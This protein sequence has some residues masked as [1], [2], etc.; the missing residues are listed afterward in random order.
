M[1]GNHSDEAHLPC[2]CCVCVF[3]PQQDPGVLGWV[4][5][6]EREGLESRPSPGEPSGA[7]A[8]PLPLS[9]SLKAHQVP[10][11]GLCAQIPLLQPVWLPEPSASPAG[12]ARPA[13][14]LGP[15]LPSFRGRQASFRCQAS[16]LG[17]FRPHTLA[18]AIPSSQNVLTRNTRARERAH[19]ACFEVLARPPSSQA[20]FVR[21]PRASAQEDDVPHTLPAL[22]NQRLKCWPVS[23]VL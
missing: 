6:L 18:H 17:L 5:G 13:A 1:K 19:L 15:Q 4:D 2:V 14:C 11:P 16:A 21:S 8:S 7:W 9:P 20:A 22:S 12:Q 3:T 10:S 23:P